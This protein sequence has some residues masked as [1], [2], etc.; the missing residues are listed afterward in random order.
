MLY[1]RLLLAR[2]LLKSD[3]AI[4][5]S[6]DDH[7]IHNLRKLADEVF[8]EEN[9]RNTFSVRRYDKNIN[10]QFLEN[11]LTSF[12]TGFEYVVCYSKT[13]VFRFN[14]VYKET[15]DDRKNYGYWKGFWND[16]DRPTMRY[17]ILGYEP[18]TGQWKWSTDRGLK[19]QKTTS[20]IV[21]SFPVSLAWKNT[22]K[23]PAKNWSLSEGIRVEKAKTKALNTG[24]R[25][26]VEYYET[27]SGRMCSLPK[28]LRK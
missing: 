13:E 27:H 2:Q 20:F 19:A 17:E 23:I 25:P 11:G 5:I 15:S 22:G 26:P 18:R 6:I 16:A 14:P 21:L 12:N 3:G 4:F 7:E 10:R 28:P 1:S 9:Y 24:F 8:G